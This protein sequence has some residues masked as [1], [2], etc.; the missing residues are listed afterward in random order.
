MNADI[1][2]QLQQQIQRACEQGTALSIIGGNSKAFYGR[3]DERTVG[4]DAVRDPPAGG[5][6]LALEGHDPPIGFHAQEGRLA[7]VPGKGDCRIGRRS[8]SAR[9][10]MS[11]AGS[12]SSSCAKMSV[13]SA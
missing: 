8:R 4:L 6:V 12:M 3:I 10:C 7:A 9:A 2:Q 13:A 1:S 5:L 11:A